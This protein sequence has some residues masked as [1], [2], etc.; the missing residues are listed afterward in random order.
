MKTP[1][2]VSDSSWDSVI[3]KKIMMK[4]EDWWK[5]DW[6]YGDQK[7]YGMEEK[8]YVK[9]LQGDQDLET[10]LKNRVERIIFAVCLLA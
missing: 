10:V 3:V 1:A 6:W 4:K 2:K 9:E 8:D 5:K 7:D